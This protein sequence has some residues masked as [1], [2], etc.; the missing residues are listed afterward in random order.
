LRNYIKEQDICWQRHLPPKL[1]GNLW[2]D[3]AQHA[4]DAEILVLSR[5]DRSSLNEACNIP[6]P[7][8]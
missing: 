2:A 6:I 3:A 1:R 8:P 4:T 5:L 7:D